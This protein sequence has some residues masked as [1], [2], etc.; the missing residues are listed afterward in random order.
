MDDADDW[1]PTGLIPKDD[2]PVVLFLSG[3]PGYRCGV[4]FYAADGR[5][6]RAHCDD[7]GR[8]EIPANS[9]PRVVPFVE[10]IGSVPWQRDAPNLIYWSRE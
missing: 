8:V 9:G 2:K 1:P 4:S 3:P 5:W 7:S 10:E 6:R